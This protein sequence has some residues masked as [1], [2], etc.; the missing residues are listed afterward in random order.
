MLKNILKLEGVVELK[1]QQ[2]LNIKGGECTA[3]YTACDAQWPTPQSGSLLFHR[4]QY[5]MFESCMTN[6]GC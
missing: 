5:N 3:V 6:H 1:K 2:Q 4:I